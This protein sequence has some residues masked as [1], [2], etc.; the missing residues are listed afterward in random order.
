MIKAH[1]Q[2]LSST[3]Q[4]IWRHAK[5]QSDVKQVMVSDTENTLMSGLPPIDQQAILAAACKNHPAPETH[6]LEKEP[7]QTALDDRDGVP[8]LAW[9]FFPT[10]SYLPTS[11]PILKRDPVETHSLLMEEQGI[12]VP[13]RIYSLPFVVDIGYSAGVLRSVPVVVTLDDLYGFSTKVAPG[14]QAHKGDCVGFIS[15]PTDEADIMENCGTF[16]LADTDSD[17]RE[18]IYVSCGGGERW[19]RPMEIKSHSAGW[20]VNSGDFEYPK[21][22]NNCEYVEMGR[23]RGT[24]IALRATVSIGGGETVYVS[25][26]DMYYAN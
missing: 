24:I 18:G 11:A 17:Q 8:H 25:Y 3:I 5:R 26:G 1:S 22:P 20:L 2:G 15:R 21:I 23:G 7:W 12:Q 19:R 14:F 4:S 10:S 9:N 16:Q 13:G 6:F